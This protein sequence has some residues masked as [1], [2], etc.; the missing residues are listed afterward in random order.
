[1]RWFVN[2]VMPLLRQQIPAVDFVVVGRRPTAELQA[3]HTAGV[4][5]LTGEV[6]DTR[7]YLCGAAVY[8]V[9]MRIGGGVRLK[10]LEAMSLALPIVSTTLGIEGIDAF[11]THC[12]RLADTPAAMAQAI[13]DMIMQRTVVS[14]ARD[15]VVAHYDWQVIIPRF[16]ALL[17]S[18]VSQRP[19]GRV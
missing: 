12:C 18:V 11:P 10:L 6:A 4:V 1:V 7:P 5:Q 8:V 16:T 15:F 17:E 9:P 19:V 3:M 13:G 14:G 2:E